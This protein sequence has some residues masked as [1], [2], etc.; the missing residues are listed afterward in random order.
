MIEYRRAKIEGTRCFFTANCAERQGNRL[1]VNN[2][3]LL[4]QV[5][6]KVKGAH[7]FEIEAIVVLPEH[8][9]CI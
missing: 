1:L 7:P 6:R 9:H 2:I 8:L 4:R 3:D 5:F